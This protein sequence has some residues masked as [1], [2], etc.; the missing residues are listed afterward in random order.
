V[1]DPTPE[2]VPELAALRAAVAEMT[3]RLDAI[4]A[5]PAPAPLVTG[6]QVVGDLEEERWRHAACLSIAQ[7]APGWD[8]PIYGESAAMTEV[9]KLRGASLHYKELA[10]RHAAERDAARLALPDVKAEI[11]NGVLSRTEDAERRAREARGDLH[12]AQQE[13]RVAARELVEARKERDRAIDAM[14]LLREEVRR[15]EA[16]VAVARSG[17]RRRAKAKRKG[18]AT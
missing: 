7:G 9:R 4:E 12:A 1:S 13:A 2:P 8:L 17:R 14:Q 16:S 10:E 3:A 18:R 11:Y 6:V 5:R 15:L